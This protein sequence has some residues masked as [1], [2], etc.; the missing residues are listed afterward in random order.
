MSNYSIPSAMTNVSAVAVSA[1]NADSTVTVGD[2]LGQSLWAGVGAFA[3][4]KPFT[5]LKITKSNYLDV[6]GQP[7]HPAS[8]SQFEPIRHVYEAVQE[9]DGYAVR[10]VADDAKFPVII[11][12]KADGDISHSTTALTYGTEVE[13][14]GNQFLALYVNDGDPSTNRHVTF[15]ADP[16]SSTRF[17]LK[18]AETNSLGVTSTL[19]TT[20][21]SFGTED[22][23][24][25]G[26]PC[27]I[28]T[29][30]EARSGYLMATCDAQAAAGVA[31][32]ATEA[33]A[34]AG[35]TNGNQAN[36]SEAQYSKAV[37]A[38]SNAN[39]NYTHVLGLGCYSLATQ[40]LLADLVND[41]RIEGFFDLKGN[42]TYAEALTAA[43]DSGLK[44][45]NNNACALYHFPFTHKDQWTSGRVNVGLSGTAYASKAKGIK[46]NSDVGGWHYSPAGEE[47][48]VIN[49]ANIKPIEGSGTPDEE[50]M[51]NARINKVAVSSTGKMIIDD[52]LTTYPE[53]NYLRFQHVSSIMNAISRAFF[54]LGRKLKHQPDNV[55]EKSLTREMTKILDRFVA[56]NALVAPRDPDSDGTAPYVLK[57]TQTE[58][59]YWKIEWACCPTGSARRLLG[60]PALIK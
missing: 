15:K 33:I 34:F 6:L 29:A 28:E 59:D 4:G 41:R 52:A 9:T 50:A 35:G 54:Q 25:M 24:S 57:V 5:A 32:T 13:L 47:R 40:K 45:A 26:R 56:S 21:I 7:I 27:Y 53:E 3:R 2:N 23:D 44:T 48:G 8:G 60:V 58:F 37:T 18:L 30:L 36:I 22:T 1:I 14:T 51:Y 49:R 12:S 31:F 19:E 20:V 11:F 10:V 39:V 46:K 42:L 55:T 17:E 43:E 16:N 38:L